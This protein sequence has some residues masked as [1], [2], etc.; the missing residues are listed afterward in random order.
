MDAELVGWSHPAGSGQQLNV[1]VK[2][3]KK[4][5]PSGVRIWIST[6]DTVSSSMSYTAGLSASSEVCRQRQA[7]TCG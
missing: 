6:V 1:Y 2:T 4:R 3:G 5:C 7:E